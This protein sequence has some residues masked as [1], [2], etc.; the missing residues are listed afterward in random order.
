[1]TEVREAESGSRGTWRQRDIIVVGASAGG[2]QA[3]TRLLAPL[4]RGLPAAIAVVMHLSPTYESALPTI[5]ARVTPLTVVAALNDAPF[6]HGQVYV[7]VPDRHLVLTDHNIGSRRDPKEHFHRPAV[8][9]LFRSAA[10]L[11]GERVVGVILS[12]SGFDGVLGA[13]SIQAAGGIVL[14]QDP[15]EARQSGMPRAVIARNVARAVLGVDRLG[16]ALVNLAAGD[17]FD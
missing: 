4:P 17:A 5:L 15:A 10:R 1:M 6:Q 13:R 8:D 2:I 16:A 3:L 12:G 9:P 11:Y 7:G 14:V